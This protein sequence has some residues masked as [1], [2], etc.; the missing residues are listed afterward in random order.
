MRKVY[1]V[2]KSKLSCKK[3]AE[4]EESIILFGTKRCPNCKLA[5][6]LLENAKID[7]KY[8]DAEDNA[9]LSKKYKIKQ[10][11]T[12]VILKDGKNKNVTGVADIKSYIDEFKI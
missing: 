5:K 2:K 12:L 6:T 8:M 1:D 7:Y 11:P 10:A 4:D 3:C 9:E